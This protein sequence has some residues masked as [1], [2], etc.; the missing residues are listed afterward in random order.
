[1]SNGD[2]RLVGLQ[3]SL[4][5]MEEYFISVWRSGPSSVQA[6]IRPR[7]PITDAVGLGSKGRRGERLLQGAASGPVGIIARIKVYVS[8]VWRAVWRVFRSQ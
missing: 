6:P 4:A 3:K 5:T 2:D 7:G 1:M 8:V